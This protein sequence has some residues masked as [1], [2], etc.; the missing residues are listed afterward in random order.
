MKK[1]LDL[2]IKKDL[3]FFIFCLIPCIPLMAAALNYNKNSYSLLCNDKL[4]IQHADNILFDQH[5]GL[6]KVT[7]SN[8]TSYYNQEQNSLCE[9]VINTIE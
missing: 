1:N 5:V 4:V 7:I 9:V 3:P 8:K 2:I 6:W